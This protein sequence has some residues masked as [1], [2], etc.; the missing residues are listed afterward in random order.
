MV[1]RQENE[2]SFRVRTAFASNSIIE[3]PATGKAAADFGGYLRDHAYLKE[4]R[5]TLLQGEDMGMPSTIFA[6]IGLER[7]RPI[8]ISSQVRSLD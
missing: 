1:A 6:D 5:I 8:K 3:D 2:T 4:G 7:G